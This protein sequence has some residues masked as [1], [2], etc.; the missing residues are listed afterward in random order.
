MFRRENPWSQILKGLSFCSLDVRL[1]EKIVR[2]VGED[3]ATITEGGM[4][5]GIHHFLT[6]SQSVMGG[7]GLN[8]FGRRGLVSNVG[9]L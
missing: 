9:P 2:A 5:L 8:I 7:D 4:N 3:P 1:K 6:Y